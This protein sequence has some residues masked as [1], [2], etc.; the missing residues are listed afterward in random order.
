MKK[1]TFLVV[2][3]CATFFANAANITLTMADYA[4]TSFTSTDGIA[5]T[6]DQATGASAP[7]YNTTSFDLRVYA[8]NTLTITAPEAMTSISFGISVKGQYRLAP[9]AA[10]VGAVEVKGT[11][12]FTAV[13]TGNATTVTF[14]VGAQ[15]EFGTDGIEKAGQLCFTT[16][17]LVTAGETAIKNV[18][19]DN[20]VYA[21]NGRV[22][23]AS[24]FQIF[25]V[26]GQNVTE[27][28]GQLNGIYIVKTANG[29]QK[30]A[31]K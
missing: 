29:I 28:N 20:S 6:A 14:T 17:D 8:S 24:E 5:V 21:I 2:A 12:D 25:S 9:I 4:A 23:A 27:L 26:A 7:A 11:P 10:S 22:Y 18:T 15:A 13:W 31:V 1:I 16:I 19:L 30:V 3:L